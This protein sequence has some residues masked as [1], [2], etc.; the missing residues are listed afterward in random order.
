MDY[1]SNDMLNIYQTHN[2]TRYLKDNYD[3][4]IGN[5]DHIYNNKNTKNY[6]YTPL[7][8]W[9]CKDI[10]N[11]LP[12]VGLMN[13]SMKISTRINKLKNLIYFQD[14][15]QYYEDILNIEI[16][17]E[18]H[19]INEETNTI[20]PLD[21]DY[22]SVKLI[23]PENIYKYKC[24]TIDKKL[25]DLKFSGIDS[26][27]ILNNY[28]SV[29]SNNNKILTI[30]DFIYL[31][32]NLKTDTLLSENTKILIGDYHYFIDYNYLLNLIPKPKISLLAEY[33]YVDDVERKLLATNKLQYLVEL[34]N[35]IVLDINKYSI[36]DS[37][38][39]FNGLVKNIYYFSQLKLKKEGESKYGEAQ[40]NNYQNNLIESIKLKL[41]NEYDIFENNE[42]V[43]YYLLES[44]LP[45]GVKIITF[46]IDPM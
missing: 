18:D 29:D 7:L 4:L 38:N 10:S 24:K 3:K 25:L 45:K 13:S 30:D 39:E 26:D 41:S 34:N 23:V 19:N 14:W 43:D 2:V 46:S 35:E 36:Y 17:R 32:N 42:M 20:T 44:Q 8:F 6:I 27:S 22:E 31:M 1:Y 15:R 37:L 16:P 33:C 28:G 11:S 40:L 21:L 12:L 9:F 5:S